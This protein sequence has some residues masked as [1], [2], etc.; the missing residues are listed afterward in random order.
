MVTSNFIVSTIKLEV[1]VSYS[2]ANTTRDAAK[3][4]DTVVG[5]VLL[6]RVKAKHHIIKLATLV[7]YT[8]THDDS[9]QGTDTDLS[10]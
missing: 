2:V 4:K 3:V 1:G 8:A 10:E 7:R 5:E 6:Q 9:P